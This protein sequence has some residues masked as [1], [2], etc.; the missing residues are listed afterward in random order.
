[1]TEHLRNGIEQS[2]IK[3]DFNNPGKTHDKIITIVNG[4]EV[5]KW[6]WKKN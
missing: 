6:V 1:M 3:I 5:I 4:K 2:L